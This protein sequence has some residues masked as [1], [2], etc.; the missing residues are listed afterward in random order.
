MGNLVNN[1]V[2]TLVTDDTHTCGIFVMYIVVKSL[3]CTTE[4]NTM[5][6]NYTSIKI[7][8]SLNVIINAILLSFC[9]FS[10]LWLFLG[11]F[12]DVH[13]WNEVND[14]SKAPDTYS[15]CFPRWLYQTVSSLDQGVPLDHW[16]I[17]SI[18]NITLKNLPYTTGGKC[19]IAIIVFCLSFQKRHVS[20]GNYLLQK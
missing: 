20:L 8:K 6:I 3:R 11:N 7:M 14:I 13:L 5:C 12:S 16:A 10:A 4:T 15:H 2:L 18:K 9:V 1:T 17:L 19:F